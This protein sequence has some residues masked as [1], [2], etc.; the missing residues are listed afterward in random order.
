MADSLDAGPSAKTLLRN[1]WRT[2]RRALLPAAA[3][4]LEAMA[5]RQLPALVPPQRSVGLYWPLAGEAD[6]RGLADLWPGRLAL[7]W[8]PAAA[9]S[10]HHGLHYRAWQPSEPLRPD[11]CGIPAPADPQAALEPAELA[12]LLVP[13]LAVDRRGLRLGYGGGWYDRLRAQPAWR[14]LRALVVLPQGCVVEALP[15]DP[16]DVP[17]HGWLSES[18]L[19][20]LPKS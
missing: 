19:V 20:L 1:H 6:L 8:A 13:A 7:P 17:F 2:R 9:A 11:G 18:E 15:A 4:G 10:E 14:D 16:W 12:L 3:A 5:R